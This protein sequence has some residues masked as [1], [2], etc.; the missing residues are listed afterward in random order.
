MFKKLLWKLKSLAYNRELFNPTSFDDPVAKQTSWYPLKG[1]G[2]NICT[3]RLKRI[4]ANRVE[5]RAALI[6]IFFYMLFF[7]VGSGVMIGS[8]VSF[9]SRSSF[10]FNAEIIIPLLIGLVFATIGGCMLYFGT[11]PIVFDNVRG[12]FWKGRKEPG[13]IFDRRN[14]KNFTGLEVVHALQIISE[15]CRGNKSSYYS[16]ELNLVLKDGKR[17]NVVDHGS[18]R[19]LREDAEILSKF[20]GIPVWDAT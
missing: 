1:G 14:Q 15:Y 2:T 19:K 13:V 3:H 16:Y 12:V 11:R 7:V 6:A 5:F 20:L 4:S 18:I 10:S 9:F 8:L 17:I